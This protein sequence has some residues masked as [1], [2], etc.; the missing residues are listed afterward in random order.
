MSNQ[1][2]SASAESQ[3]LQAGRDI[4]ISGLSPADVV[5]ITRREV[6]RVAGELTLSAKTVA[7]ERVEALGNKILE[8]F[9][10]TPKHLDAFKDPDFQFSLNDAGRAAA[11]NDDE[12]T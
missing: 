2:Q 7:E 8:R 9:A 10:Q 5:E 1:K 12:H 6:A 3:L 11:S 4:V